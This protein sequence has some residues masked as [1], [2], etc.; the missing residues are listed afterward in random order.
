VVDEDLLLFGMT[1]VV[2]IP[3]VDLVFILLLEP[4]VTAG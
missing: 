4:V 2:A 1:L 3:D